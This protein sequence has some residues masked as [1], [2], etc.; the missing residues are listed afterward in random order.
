MPKPIKLFYY[1]LRQI[2][3]VLGA[4]ISAPFIYFFIS[5]RKLFR[6]KDKPLKIL[7][8]PHLTRI[9]DLVCATPVFHTIKERYPDAY[10][11]VLVAGR[12]EPILK[13]NPKV[14]EII[15]YR[16]F[17][18]WG[19][20]KK[21][22]VEKFDWS[23]SLSGTAVSSAI[24]FW[25]LIPN[26]AKITRRPR[27]FSEILTDR[28]ANFKLRYTHHEYLP[29]YYLKLLEFIGIENP[30]EVKEVFT[31]E[32]GE[33]KALEFL[34]K[35]GV[36]ARDSFVGISVTAGNK[37]KEW[38]DEKFKELAEKIREKY[39]CKIIFIASKRDEE[40]VG[41]ILFRGAISA[42]D[43]SLEELPSLIKRLKLFIAVDTGP[44]YI[45]HALRVPLIDIIGP[46]DPLEQ[47]P[48]DERSVQALPAGDIKPSSFVMKKPGRPEE[49]RKATAS[50]KV[51]DVLK[52]VERLEKFLK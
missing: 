19:T 35:N 22:R 17:D 3:L 33:K 45:A 44:I 28:F 24:A 8:I 46:V 41:K 9:G 34:N 27:P 48:N 31:S 16:H 4:I 18:L 49:H 2:V 39:G 32:A 7:V 30:R 23:F 50:I 11:A 15:I 20:I 29:R 14:D 5:R 26:R 12:I 38:G 47:P 13:N 52:S 21:I 42:T 40:R 36:G 1:W 6:P 10:L 43:F 37:I 51:E 25:G